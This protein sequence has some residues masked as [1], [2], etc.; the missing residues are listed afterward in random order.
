MPSDRFRAVRAELDVGARLGAARLGQ[1]RNRRAFAF[2]VAAT[3]APDANATPLTTIHRLV[4]P[5]WAACMMRP[6]LATATATQKKSQRRFIFATAF[7]PHP[8]FAG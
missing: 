4:G 5:M 8:A 2:S 6:K 1:G 7:V 3:M